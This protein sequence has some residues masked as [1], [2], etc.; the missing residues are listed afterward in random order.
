MDVMY[1]TFPH[2]SGKW[3]V[4]A[5]NRAYLCN[6]NARIAVVEWDTVGGMYSPVHL[7]PVVVDAAGDHIHGTRWVEGKAVQEGNAVAGAKKFDSDKPMMDLLFDGCP[8]A[9]SGVGTVLTYGFKK[10]GGK[11]GWKSLDDAVKRYEA[12]LLRHQLLKASGEMLDSESGLPHTWHIACN[13]LFL[14]ELEGYR[15]AKP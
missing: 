2:I 12:A 4:A 1:W 15:A 8:L 6:G 14:A 7:V 5:G 10:Y 11:H 9:V 3:S 13:A